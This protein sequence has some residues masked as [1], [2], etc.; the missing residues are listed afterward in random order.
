MAKPPGFDDSSKLPDNSC[1]P[2][3][4][5]AARQR[6]IPNYAL[7]GDAL[8]SG[9][10]L[11]FHFEWI[12]DR[13]RLH[14]WEI[15]PHTHD[16][17][18]QI[19]LLQQGACELWLGP[20][21]QRVQAPCLLLVPA[22]NVHGFRFTPDVQGPIVMAAQA[23]LE[24]LVSALMPQLLHTLRSPAV[25]PL[26]HTPRHVQ[27]LMALF[28]ALE[29]EWRMHAPGQAA[30]GLSLLV[31]LLVRI[32]RVGRTLGAPAPH[33]PSAL[34]RKA[35][36]VERFRALVD[37][38]FAQRLPLSAYADELGLSVGQLTRLCGELLG[39]SSLAVV[40]ARV[41]RQAQSQLL[42]TASSV[43]QVAADLGFADEA[44][45]GRFFTKHTGSTPSAFRTQLR[46]TFWAAGAAV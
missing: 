27:A 25:L 46:Q 24:A 31:A 34:S 5:N 37:E 32:A 1:M 22:Q 29:Q 35:L 16:A 6:R 11:P 8:H 13:S 18:V 2:A 43:K 23:P 4:P 7:Y 17:L 3:L 38:R 33:A 10:A 40:N 9:A 19:M 36:Q 41:L 12:P 20:T 44:Y 28:T 42:Y 45:F 21:Q 26:G 15:K 14:H 39:Q 30:A